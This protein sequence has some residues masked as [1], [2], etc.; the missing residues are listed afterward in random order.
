MNIIMKFLE[1]LEGCPIYDEIYYENYT[2]YKYNVD[3]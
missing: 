1:E 3:Y 2:N